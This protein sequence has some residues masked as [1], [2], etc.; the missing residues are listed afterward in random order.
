MIIGVMVI[1]Y[2]TI[3]IGGEPP[4]EGAAHPAACL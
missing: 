2:T 4:R 1:R 3:Q